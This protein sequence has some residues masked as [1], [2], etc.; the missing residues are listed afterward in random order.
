MCVLS[1]FDQKTVHF[2]GEFYSF[3]TYMLINFL[4]L[5]CKETLACK[6]YCRPA[7][8]QPKSKIMFYKNS[9]P[10]DLYGMTLALASD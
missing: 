2:K 1:Y 3:L 6:Q 4:V 10:C 5:R 7:Q 9:S 8:N